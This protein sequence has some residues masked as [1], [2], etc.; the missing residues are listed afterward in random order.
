MRNNNAKP[1]IVVVTISEELLCHNA[2]WSSP[3][4]SSNLRAIELAW[5]NMIIG[6]VG[7]QSKADTSFKDALV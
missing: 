7:Q 1:I 6:D 4:H 2:V 3:Y 5:D